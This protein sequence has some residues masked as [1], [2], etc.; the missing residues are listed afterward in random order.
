MKTKLLFSIL[1]FAIIFVVG[2]DKDDDTNNN[3]NDDDNLTKREKAIKDYKDNYLGSDV[4]DPG[5]TGSTT[6]CVAGTC[7]DAA[8]EKVVQR[9]NYFRRL[10]GLPD[11]IT[12]NDNQTG[13]CQQGAMMMK[14]HYT[15][16]SGVNPHN[17]PSSWKCYTQGAAYAARGSNIAWSSNGGA[18]GNHTTNAVTGYIEDKGSH[19]KRVGHRRWILFSKLEKIGHGSTNSTNYLMW[20]DNLASSIPSDVPDYHAYPAEG[21][22]PNALVFARWS[23]SIPGTQADFSNANI[24]MTDASGNNINLN[25]IHKTSAG[26]SYVGDNT[27]V[28]EPQGINTS[29]SSD[30]TYTVTVSNISGADKS[31]YTYDVTL[32]PV[33]S[34][35][36]SSETKGESRVF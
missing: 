25:I 24:D 6:G 23:F 28:W 12:L 26:G 14:R 30:V 4:D 33:S 29:S 7:S 18:N 17:P 13:D 36:K 21:Y 32:V 22:M 35:A 9:V 8:V 11:N 2:C 31:S 3:N 27:I 5:W 16:G 20:K 1:A 10:V 15:P 34:P 19:N